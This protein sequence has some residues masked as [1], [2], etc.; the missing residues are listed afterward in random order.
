MA[1]TGET[2]IAGYVTLG[3]TCPVQR[4]DL[5]CPDR[6]YSARITVWRDGQM[7]AETTSSDDGWFK[8]ILEP[9]AY[10]LVGESPGTLP[11]GS[12]QTVVVR[13][14]TLT[15]VQVTYDTGIR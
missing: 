4:A 5:P 13:G 10:R 9:G 12:E 3:P 11:H 14:G 2:G 1:Q 8:V 7:V 15:G 6:P